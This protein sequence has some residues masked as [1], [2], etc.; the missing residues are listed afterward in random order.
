GWACPR[1]QYLS[2]KPI[3]RCPWCGTQMMAVDDLAD[4]AIQKAIDLEGLVDVVGG[5]AA[6]RL[7]K[8]GGMGAVLR[9]CWKAPSIRKWSSTPRPPA[10]GAAASRPG[11]RST[12]CPSLKR[13]CLVTARQ[14]KRW[15][16]ARGKWV[17][18]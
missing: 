2:A 14:P 16:A 11:S 7:R 1:D 12:A 17:C 4:R 8:H 3:D 6:D 15:Y 10:P 18:R 13:T 5:E 9:F